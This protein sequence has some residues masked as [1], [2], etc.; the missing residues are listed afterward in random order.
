MKFQR[1]GISS[2]EK[3]LNRPYQTP[4]GVSPGLL[5]KHPRFSR[6]YML[7]V[8][9]FTRAFTADLLR[10][11]YT[12][13]WL[14]ASDTCAHAQR[15]VYPVTRCIV[16]W[17]RS[18]LGRSIG[19][20]MLRTPTGCFKQ[21]I[22]ER[23]LASS[24]LCESETKFCGKPWNRHPGRMLLWKVGPPCPRQ[25]RILSQLGLNFR[26]FVSRHAEN[27]TCRA[28][29]SCKLKLQNSVRRTPKLLCVDSCF[30]LTLVPTLG[31]F[32]NVSAVFQSLEI[33][34]I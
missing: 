4:A 30:S 26:R 32:R 25:L 7:H 15:P 17:H 21:P 23:P 14:P 34:E 2:P 24:K 12:R 28:T 20:E 22:I 9:V 10:I 5:P 33:W 29:L 8:N 13:I 11:R 27:V 3:S 19:W 16:I 18:N 6:E 1:G 31:F